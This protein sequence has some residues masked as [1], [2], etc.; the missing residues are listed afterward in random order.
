MPFNMPFKKTN[1]LQ[2]LS[3]LFSCAIAVPTPQ[4]VFPLLDCDPSYTITNQHTFEGQFVTGDYTVGGGEK[5]YID[6]VP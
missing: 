5:S 3:L 6:F 2:F 4:D 1:T